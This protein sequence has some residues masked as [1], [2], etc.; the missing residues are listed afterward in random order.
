MTTITAPASASSERSRD[1]ENALNGM[2]TDWNHQDRMLKR[3]VA[4]RVGFAL[5][6]SLSPITSDKQ[7]DSLYKAISIAS[8]M[9]LNQWYG[10]LQAGSWYDVVQQ[11]LQEPLSENAMTNDTVPLITHHDWETANEGWEVTLRKRFTC[12][13]VDM[14]GDDAMK[15]AVWPCLQTRLLWALDL[16]SSTLSPNQKDTI[17]RSMETVDE[18]T[19]REVFNLLQ[20]GDWLKGVTTLGSLSSETSY[21]LD[22]IREHWDDDFEGGALKVWAKRLILAEE[23]FQRDNPEHYAKAIDIVQ[24]SGMGKSRLVSEMAKKVMTISFV[25]RNPGETGFPPGDMEIL[26][27]LLA[28]DPQS[29]QNTHMRAMC[30]LGGTFFEG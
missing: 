24:S 7:K 21:S 1:W 27:F 17:R 12:W 19:I 18:P 8:E 3:V 29:V 22:D 26:D 6:H 2:F 5:E 9:D 30:L 28:G 4:T 15:K 10:M 20:A 11:I 23:N 14:S 13:D 25:L 16:P